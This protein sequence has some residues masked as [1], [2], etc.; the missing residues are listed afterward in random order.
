MPA[1]V[2]PGKV[3][4]MEH[5]GDPAPTYHWGISFPGWDI[6]GVV[7]PD[8]NMHCTT[9]AVPRRTAGDP[10]TMQIRGH[11]FER[12]AAYNDE[13]T[14][15]MEFIDTTDNPISLWLSG[16]RDFMWDTRTGVRGAAAYADYTVDCLMHRY[17]NADND[18]PIWHYLL[19]GCYYRD[20]D[21]VGGQLGGDV[22]V[23]RPTLT[24]YYDWF[25]DGPGA[26]SSGSST[27]GP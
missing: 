2:R 8:V 22:E 20:A 17:G 15:D 14:L 23:L 27:P 6:P 10:V 5:L 25:V 12:P 1:L 26:A 9:T 13:H 3:D 4:I 7:L 21:P 24:L 16:W 19:H 18:T 11:Q